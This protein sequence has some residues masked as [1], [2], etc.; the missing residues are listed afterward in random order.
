MP[1]DGMKAIHRSA[2]GI[3]AA[4]IVLFASLAVIVARRTSE[5]MTEEAERTV[6]GVVK[7]TA[8]RIDRQLLA[9]ETATRNFAWIVDEHLEDPDHMY[10]ITRKL[11]ENNEFIAGSFIAFEPG[12]YK[13]KGR[14]Y[15]PCSYVSTNGQVRSLLLQHEYPAEEWYRATKDGRR[16]RWCEPYLDKNL[17]EKMCTFSLPLTNET[18]EVYAVLGTTISLAHMTEY[19]ST[20]CPYPQSHAVLT[21]QAGNYLV[22]PPRGQ[23]F[24][25]GEKTITIREKTEN[26][27]VVAVV[28]PMEDILKETRQL[29]TS[30]VLIAVIGLLIIIPVS[31]THVK[32]LQRE[33][34]VREWA[35]N[36]LETAVNG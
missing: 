19:V 26:G 7:E 11:V 9:V 35:A 6:K 18:G 27:W 22:M 17:G 31:W 28:C 21:S 14:L 15:A 29:V 36:N 3:F 8:V 23:T 1:N 12:F 33:S 10:R 24:E 32:R 4:V 25:R 5:M 13:A 16:A 20:I 30:I 2:F 34:V